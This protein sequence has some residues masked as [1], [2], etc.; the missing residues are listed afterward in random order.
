MTPHEKKIR[1]SQKE[2]NQAGC[3]D[4]RCSEIFSDIELSKMCRRNSSVIRVRIGN[5]VRLESLDLLA[6]LKISPYFSCELFPQDQQLPVEVHDSLNPA[7][8]QGA[9]LVPV[10]A[11]AP[12]QLP[13]AVAGAQ[14]LR[15]IRSG[16]GCML[17][18]VHTGG[19]SYLEK[20][21]RNCGGVLSQAGSEMEELSFWHLVAV[22]EQAV[23]LLHYSDFA[24]HPSSANFKEFLC[25][26]KNLG[27]ARDLHCLYYT[28]LMY[29][30][31]S[32]YLNDFPI[33]VFLLVYT[34]I[35][36]CF[37]QAILNVIGS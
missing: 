9:E 7:I 34:C 15:R 20:R 23:T 8:R 19:C 26:V 29:L 14:P 18:G 32:L 22:R 37:P 33:S 3:I 6:S 25:L 27:S 16:M 36:S 24:Y 21:E 11:C 2:K 4:S 31:A 10:R 5:L 35:Y 1:Q 17:L 13:G 28:G 12:P 30:H